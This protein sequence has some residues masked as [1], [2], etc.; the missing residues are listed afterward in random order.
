MDLGIYLNTGQV[1]FFAPTGKCGFPIGS[2]YLVLPIDHCD[3]H[4]GNY[5]LV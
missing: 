2:D 5:Y 4:I 1:L 3:F